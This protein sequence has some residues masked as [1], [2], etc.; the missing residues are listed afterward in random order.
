[1]ALLCALSVI[2]IV[3]CVIITVKNKAIVSLPQY[4]NSSYSNIFTKPWH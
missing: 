1:M 2:G 3:I 4:D